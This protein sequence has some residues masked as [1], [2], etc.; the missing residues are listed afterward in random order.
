MFFLSPYFV[1]KRNLNFKAIGVYSGNLDVQ[2]TTYYAV[3][4]Q[5]YKIEYVIHKFPAGSRG[6]TNFPCIFSLEG[7]FGEVV[8]Y[9][10]KFRNL[11]YIFKT[12]KVLMYRIK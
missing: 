8:K 4:F 11:L 7:K 5:Y 12:E 10:K 2:I 1:S 3:F 6:R 9:F